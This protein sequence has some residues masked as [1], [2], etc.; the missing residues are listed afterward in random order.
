MSTLLAQTPEREQKAGKPRTGPRLRLQGQQLALVLLITALAAGF[1]SRAP[2]FLSPASIENLLRSASMFGIV[3][4][5][6]TIVILA[7]GS[8]GGI[9]LSVGSMMALGGAIGA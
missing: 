6:M 4:L 7:C 1:A 8:L 5:G 3:G 2:E 9:D